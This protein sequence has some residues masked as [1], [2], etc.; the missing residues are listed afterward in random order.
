MKKAIVLIGSPGSGKGTQ[1]ELLA[2]RLGFFHFES[3]LIVK[4]WT[5]KHP[6]HP[7]LEKSMESYKKGG[8]FEPELMA[9]VIKEET[10]R[11]L[12]KYKGIIYDGSPRT[13]PE[14]HEVWPF[15]K[16]TFGTSNII[17]LNL[18]LDDAIA[19]ARLM[20]RLV[21]EFDHAYI[22]GENG[23]AV[24]SK[25]PKDGS[26]LKIRDL[27]DPKVVEVRFEEFKKQTEPAIELLRHYV[28]VIDID[29]DHAR[30]E[31]FASVIQKITPY[32]RV[33][34]NGITKR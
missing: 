29:A 31:T 4:H 14:T 15:W 8:L 3:S 33:L 12:K 34:K 28:D 23:L 2:E 19:R 22:T 32:F 27:D 13:L 10:E 5:Q 17:V 24:T 18:K 26:P 6:R 7:L 30:P 21:C 1:A 20:T 11:I 16:K 9:H 25:C